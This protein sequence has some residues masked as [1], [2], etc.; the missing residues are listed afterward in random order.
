MEI[1]SPKEPVYYYEC[2]AGRYRLVYFIPPTELERLHA[3]GHISRQ[4]LRDLPDGADVG[5]TEADFVEFE[6]LYGYRPSYG[7]EALQRAFFAIFSSTHGWETFRGS[8]WIPAKDLEAELGVV[9]A[10]L[11]SAAVEPPALE[12]PPPR[13]TLRQRRRRK[14]RRS[15]EQRKIRKV[16]QDL[17]A[18]VVDPA[19]YLS[20]QKFSDIEMTEGKPA[21]QFFSEF[22]LKQKR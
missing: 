3:E 18:S 16:L 10:E 12:P 6:E 22:H 5:C 1:A 8:G 15:V 21:E 19:K 11:R 4:A 9:E 17:P 14:K 13:A 20:Q 2:S 7:P